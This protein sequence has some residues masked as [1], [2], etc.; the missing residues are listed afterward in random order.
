MN[1]IEFNAF[2][3]DWKAGV[4]H[5]NKNRLGEDRKEADNDA[6]EIPEKES[7]ADLGEA[8]GDERFPTDDERMVDREE[9]NREG[10][11]EA[12]AGEDEDEKTDGVDEKGFDEAVEKAINGAGSGGPFI[13]N[14]QDE[15]PLTPQDVLRRE[16]EEEHEEEYKGGEEEVNSI[17]DE[18]RDANGGAD[19]VVDQVGAELFGVMRDAEE[20][21]DQEELDNAVNSV[22]SKKGPD[23]VNFKELRTK[24][25]VPRLK[26]SFVLS[27][28]I[29]TV[30]VFLVLVN[31]IVGQNKRKAAEA[32]RRESVYLK[33]GETFTLGDYR[34]RVSGDAPK[35]DEEEDFFVPVAP[36][37][38]DAIRPVTPAT[39]VYRAPVASGSRYSERDLEAAKAKIKK[40]AGY[41]EEGG[42]QLASAQGGNMMDVAMNPLGYIAGGAG[43]MPSKDEYTA[44]RINDIASL[45]NAS[46][47]GGD[48]QE[49]FGENPNNGRYSQG[50]NYSSENQGAGEFQYINET[51]LF[52]GTIIHAVLQ[53]RIDTDYPGPIFARVTENVYDSKTGRNLLIPQGTI[54]MGDYSSSSIGVAKV[55]IAWKQMI[56]NYDDVAYQVSLGG[57]AGV[58]KRGRA[59]IS[60]TLDDHYFEWLKAAGI[61]SLF[62]M[63][64]S[65]ISY[66]MGTQK[67]AQVRELM[68]TNQALMNQ[69]GERI[70][71]R[72]LDIQPT[73]RVANGKAVSVA[74]NTVLYLR[75]FEE[76]KAEEKY[77]R[78]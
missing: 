30:G 14:D 75:P 50:G 71:E 37:A 7:G 24:G 78:R 60:G 5:E 51:A 65:E 67:T 21:E 38:Y 35:E 13:E 47:V 18:V 1:Q 45:V 54:L 57:M 66:Q 3:E 56:V 73:V 39:T 2:F 19:E 31:I 40:D 59:G 4:S 25:K 61:V 28:V 11:V 42:S 36:P 49:N 41:G 69:L 16:H 44:Q 10:P 70:M 46:G 20:E 55:Q 33:D 9:E 53:S 43:G 17:D 32:N 62:T 27:L 74:V 23:K 12:D 58:D 34:N 77:I 22:R 63:F 64:N 6:P 68:D 8:G 15:E 29:G 48:S 26:K 72:A 76:I 52:P